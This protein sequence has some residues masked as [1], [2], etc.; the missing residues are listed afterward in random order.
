M[1]AESTL[2][3]RVLSICVRKMKLDAQFGGD[4]RNTIANAAENRA[5]SKKLKDSVVDSDQSPL[6][7][8][9]S[10]DMDE[11]AL[12]EVRANLR[13]EK[14]TAASVEATESGLFADFND[15]KLF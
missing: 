13:A 9:Q 10:P 3:E 4:S 11:N 1:L 12:D 14:T 6:S 5:D 7:S 8:N 2:E 15:M